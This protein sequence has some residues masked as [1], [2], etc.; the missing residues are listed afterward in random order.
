MQIIIA[1]G[2]LHSAICSTLLHTH[3]HA[4]KQVFKS[5]FMHTN[6]QREEAAELK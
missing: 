5:E 2:D 3:T 1:S 6:T 4:H